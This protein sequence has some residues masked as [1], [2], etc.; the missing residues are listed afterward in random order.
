MIGRALGLRVSW[1]N[2][3]EAQRAVSISQTKVLLLR[4]RS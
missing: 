1:N 3:K 2:A 4:A